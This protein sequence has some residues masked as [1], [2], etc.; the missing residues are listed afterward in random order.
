MYVGGIWWDDDF[1][2]FVGIIFDGR[3]EKEGWVDHECTLTDLGV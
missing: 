3:I 1:D 2:I